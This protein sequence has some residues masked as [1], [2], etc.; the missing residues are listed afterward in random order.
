MVGLFWNLET[1]FL[2]R[3]NF[4][5]YFHDSLAFL[6]IQN[7]NN[8]EN[9]NK[10]KKNFPPVL[11][12]KSINIRSVFCVFVFVHCNFKDEIHVFYQIGIGFESENLYCPQ[13]FHSSMTCH[14]PYIALVAI[15]KEESS[16]KPMMQKPEIPNMIITNMTILSL[17]KR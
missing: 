10:N 16:E 11:I 5:Y 9:N 15:H 3:E 6:I 1:Y 4:R 7:P 17:W 14:S 12:K 2:V 8:S 13:I